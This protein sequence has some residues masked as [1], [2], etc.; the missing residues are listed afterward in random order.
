MIKDLKICYS[1]VNKLI[2]EQL[3]EKVSLEEGNRQETCSNAESM[4]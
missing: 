4:A 2:L 3:I 1:L